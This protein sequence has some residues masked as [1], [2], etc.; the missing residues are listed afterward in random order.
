VTSFRRYESGVRGL[1]V[2]EVGKLVLK[3]G[4]VT[5]TLTDDFFCDPSRAATGACGA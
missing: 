2:G 4:I 3:N 1:H 5:N